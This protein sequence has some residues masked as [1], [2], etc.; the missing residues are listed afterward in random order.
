MFKDSYIVLDVLEHEGEAPKTLSEIQV[1]DVDIGNKV[2]KNIS[3][4]LSGLEGEQKKVSATLYYKV[5]QSDS[6]FQKV[7]SQNVLISK[8]PVTMSITGP[9]SL[10]VA[11]DGEYTVSIRGVSKVIPALLITLD[12]PKQMK[13]IKT[14]L[15]PVSKNTFSLGPIN[16]GEEKTF[17][18]TGSFQDAPEIGDKFTLKVR[19]GSGDSNEVK[20][21]FSENTYGV[22]LAQNPIDIKILAENQSGEKISFSGKQPKAKVVITN[23]SNVRVQN[24]EL[25]LKFSGGL[26]VPKGVSVDG[27]VYDST[28]FTATANPTTNEA[29][30]EIDPGDSVEFPIEFSEIADD[31]TVSG[32]SLNI[33]VA[34]TSI[35]EGSEGKPT[36]DRMA[37]TLTPKE[38]TNASLSTFYF[39]GAFKN[40]GPMPATVGQT[41]TYTINLYV[42]TNSGFVN[43]KFIVPLPPNVNYVKA[44]DNTVTYSKDQRT[45]TWNVGNLSKAT[46]TAFVISI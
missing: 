29:L 4:N 35:P 39:S 11:Q 31:K 6:V 18:F 2:Y 5:P 43:G 13:I 27:A 26:L 41:T 30:K 20:S 22:N 34:F 24:G 1:G 42:D 25:V 23:K 10:S 3:M 16:E 14:S 33:Q 40:T 46:S 28:K 44:L 36:T 17:K 19:A 38:G 12:T 15:Q 9:Q 8:S 7:I 45:V 32:R 21:Y 37:T